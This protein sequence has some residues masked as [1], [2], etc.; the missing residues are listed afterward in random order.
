MVPHAPSTSELRALYRQCRRGG[1]VGRTSAGCDGPQAADRRDSVGQALDCRCAQAV[2]LE[3]R[4]PPVSS[5]RTLILIA[6]LVIGALAAFLVFNYVNGAD[7][8]A[9]D[10]AAAGR[11]V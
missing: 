6:A 9:Q 2:R 5:R 7:D 1:R 3:E 10:N 11:R 8:R 4:G